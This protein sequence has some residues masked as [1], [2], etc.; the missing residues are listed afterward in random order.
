MNARHCKDCK[1]LKNRIQDGKFSN[2][3]DKR[4]LDENGKLWN[5]NR[6]PDCVVLKVRESMRIS[7]SKVTS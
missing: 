7:R 4:W 6:C 2:G 5:G 1:L 3:R